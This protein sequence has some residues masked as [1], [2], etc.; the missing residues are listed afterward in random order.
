MGEHGD[1]QFAVWS[2]TRVAG[3]PFLEYCKQA[4]IVIDKEQIEK[5]I[6]QAGAKVIQKKGVTNYG[7]AILVAD[8]CSAILKN[9]HSIY[10]VSS[11][12]NG[13]CGICDVCISVPTIMGL[14]GVEKHIELDFT[15]EEFIR[16]R[17]SADR[18]KSFLKSIDR[19]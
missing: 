5:D 9:K 2:S 3:M 6:M 18:I 10:N 12:L 17:S 15:E 13:Y 7:I 8:L 1:S 4:N 11:M 16:L 19:L 14:N